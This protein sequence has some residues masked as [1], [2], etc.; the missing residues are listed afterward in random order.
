LAEIE[1]RSDE[2]LYTHDG[3]QIGRLDPVFKAGWPIREAQVIQESLDA[4]RVRLVAS[5]GFDSGIQ[6]EVARQLRARLGN[7]NVEFE[8]VPEIPRGANGKFRSVICNL[9]AAE[10]ARLQLPKMSGEGRHAIQK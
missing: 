1:G 4:I 8:K 2:M 3:R 7:V 9:S 10:K 6:Q 5:D